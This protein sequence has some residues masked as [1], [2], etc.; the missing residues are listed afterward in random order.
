MPD[1]SQ[2]KKRVLKE[3]PKAP[4]PPPRILTKSELKE[5]EYRD[6]KL[7]NIVKIKLSPLMEMLK[8]RYKRFRKPVIVKLFSLHILSKFYRTLMKYGI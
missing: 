4:T 5:L 6:R 3:L 1:D 2:R 8:T 7:K